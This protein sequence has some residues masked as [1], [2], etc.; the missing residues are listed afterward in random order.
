M[1]VQ[2][3][4]RAAILPIPKLHSVLISLDP[5]KTKKVQI[6]FGRQNLPGH[7]NLGKCSATIM[8]PR[9]RRKN[10][11]SFVHLDW[12]EAPYAIKKNVHRLVSLAV[13]HL[14]PTGIL[15]IPLAPKA[16]EARHRYHPSRSQSYFWWQTLK[17]YNGYS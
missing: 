15:S 13:R 9:G 12:A 11:R 10:V 8:I 4:V 17:N 2:T 1:P 16:E 14:S 7:G 6:N 5:V 3:Y